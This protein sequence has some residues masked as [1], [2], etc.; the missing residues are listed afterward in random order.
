MSN[1]IAVFAASVP[2]LLSAA[3][4]FGGEVHFQTPATD[5]AQQMR[6]LL[7][8]AAQAV[9]D[10]VSRTA[11]D[12]I[13][14][15]WLFPTGDEHTV[16]AQYTVNT[17]DT[18]SALESSQVHLEV[19][20]MQGDR[21]VEQRDLTRA[22]DDNALRAQHTGGGRDWSASIGNG[23]ATSIETSTLSAGSPASAHWSA[24]IGSGHVSDDSIQRHQVAGIATESHAPQ[25]HWT[26]KIGSARA[27]DSNTNIQTVKSTS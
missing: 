5:R 13:S 22:A 2:L 1:K 18:S 8:R 19:L 21:V 4:A 6:P 24:L 20:S 11:A 14:N 15:L 26:S 12:H 10:K 17:K 3:G 16:F 25:A 9:H 7:S 23:H 27:V